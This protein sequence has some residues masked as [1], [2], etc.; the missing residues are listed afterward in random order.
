M[1]SSLLR[2]INYFMLEKNIS[3]MEI[4]KRTEMPQ[5]TLSLILSGK[6]GSEIKNLRRICKALEI[7]MSTFFMK[8]ADF[9]RE[10]ENAD[11]KIIFSEAFELM[12]ENIKD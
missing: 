2:A 8:V 6:R 5:S 12:A 9:E 10:K 3:Q 1:E 4:V 11:S 7:N